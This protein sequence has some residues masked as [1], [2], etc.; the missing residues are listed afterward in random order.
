MQEVGFE[1]DFLFGAAGARYSAICKRAPAAVQA[2][3]AHSF[4]FLSIL[5]R[6]KRVRGG[7]FE[8]ASVHC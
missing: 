4:S 7:G 2:G 8:L 6:S 3:P 5:E 1:R